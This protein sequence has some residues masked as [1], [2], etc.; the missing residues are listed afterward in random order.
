MQYFVEL[1]RKKIAYILYVTFMV[2]QH[3]TSLCGCFGFA[4]K[5]VAWVVFLFTLLCYAII[6]KFSS[7]IISVEGPDKTRPND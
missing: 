7:T 2:R 3:V 4:Y 6:T 1:L 5:C